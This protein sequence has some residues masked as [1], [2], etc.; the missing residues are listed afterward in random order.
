M[1]VNYKFHD[2]VY[3]DFNIDAE[4]SGSGRVQIVTIEDDHGTDVDFDDFTPEERQIIVEMAKISRDD[5]DRLP[6]AEEP[7]EDEDE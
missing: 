4:V 5:L 2:K 3:G 7:D 6:D 1:R